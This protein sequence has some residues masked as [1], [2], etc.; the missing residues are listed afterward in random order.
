MFDVQARELIRELLDGD[1]NDEGERLEQRQRLLKDLG[2]DPLVAD[3][4]ETSLLDEG[5]CRSESERSW[6]KRALPLVIEC[7]IYRHLTDFTQEL[8]ARKHEESVRRLAYHDVQ[9]RLQAALAQAENHSEDLKDPTSKSWSLRDSAEELVTTIEL[10]GTVLQNLMQGEYLPD[11]Y[12]FEQLDLREIITSAISLAQPMAERKYITIRPL[13]APENMRI[14]LQASSIHL[15]QAFNNLIHN[16]VKYSYRGGEYGGRQVSVR[17]TYAEQGFRIVIENYGIGILE[18]EYD[19]IF[20][21][22]YKGILRQKER[23]T[24]SGLGLPLT[25]QIIEK[26]RGRIGVESEPMGDPARDKTCPYLTRFTVWLPLTQPNQAGPAIRL[27]KGGR[28][29]K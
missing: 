25:M 1:R 22:G 20:E 23:R 6:L 7:I 14:M 19:R 9:L 3:Q 28:D 2:V 11:D 27:V 8:R 13:I 16:A 5:L 26:H 18:E 12:L 24:G 10:A 17:G 15:Q 29:G 4:I 21:P